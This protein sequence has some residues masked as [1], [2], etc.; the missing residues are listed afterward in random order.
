MATVRLIILNGAHKG[1]EL[2]LE[3]GPNLLGRA[4]GNAFVLEDVT[5]SGRHCEILVSDLSVRVRDLGSTN[6]T[7]IDNRR[8]QD[9][10]MR[11]GQILMLGSMEMQLAISPVEI[12]IPP[13]ATPLEP[14]PTTLEDGRPACLNH[15]GLPATLKCGQCGR[16]YCE[17]CVRELHLVGG[18]SRLFCPGCS[19]L[20]LPLAGVALAGKKS[21][22]SRLLETIRITFRRNEP[23]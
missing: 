10:E 14:M 21:F 13:L 12:T 2:E 20:C 5:L 22:A 15:P 7:W 4:E 23:K 1:E 9:A 18:R 8:V 6:G 11:H 3:P 19:G 17:A 16:T